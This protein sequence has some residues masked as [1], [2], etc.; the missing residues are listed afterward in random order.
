[1]CFS[2]RY[3]LPQS[4]PVKNEAQGVKTRKSE[5]ICTPLPFLHAVVSTVGKE[6]GTENKVCTAA[7]KSKPEDLQGK[8]KHSD[9]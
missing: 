2:L 5:E 3:L 6:E 1:M 9:K 7:V 8:A 4:T